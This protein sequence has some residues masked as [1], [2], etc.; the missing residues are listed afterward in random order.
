MWHPMEKKEKA[1]KTERIKT[2]QTT[3]G[4]EKGAKL[5]GCIPRGKCTLRGCRDG[6][7]APLDE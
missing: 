4:K 2:K 3:E 1:G 5:T 6:G 7:G